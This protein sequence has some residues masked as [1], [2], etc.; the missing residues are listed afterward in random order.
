MGIETMHSG[1]GYDACAALDHP[2]TR[3]A[4]TAERAM[5]A[6]LGGGCQIPIGAYA[7]IA[8]D[9]LKL[10]G[11]VAAT[12]DSTVVLLDYSSKKSAAVPAEMRRIIGE[13]EGKS[14]D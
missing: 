14:F 3:F 1:A 10:L 12:A 2:W 4:V 8:D 5:L 6:E 7:E 13:L 9:K 11:V